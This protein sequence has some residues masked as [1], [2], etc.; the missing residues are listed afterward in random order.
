MKHFDDIIKKL[1]LFWQYPVITEK[2][3]Y[4]QQYNNIN[5]YGIPWATLIDKNYNLQVISKLLLAMVPKREYITCCQHIY[6][7]QLIPM[8]KILNIKTVYT[9]HKTKGEDNIDGIEIKPCPLYAV[10]IED[11]NRNKIIR[12]NN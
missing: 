1:K 12:I 5:Y 8:F 7:K 9:P 3:V 10:N 6:F 4:E 11:D 2:T